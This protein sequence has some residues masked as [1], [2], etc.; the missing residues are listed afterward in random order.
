ML[1]SLSAASWA[2]HFVFTPCT[3]HDSLLWR[4]RFSRTASATVCS[5][6]LCLPV[7]PCLTSREQLNPDV[8]V[9]AYLCI[10]IYMYMNLY[11]L[12]LIDIVS[13]THTR[14][15]THTYTD[16]YIYIYIC[17]QA[18]HGPHPP[19]AM[20]SPCPPAPL[21]PRTHVRQRLRGWTGGKVGL[22]Q[23]MPSAPTRVL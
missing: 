19:Q 21:P 10:Y 16:I 17:N 1:P 4:H 7:T 5:D 20:A 11:L 15:H 2:L 6:C 13:H 9:H 23:P 14:T 18:L 12:K 3:S 8:V 22:P